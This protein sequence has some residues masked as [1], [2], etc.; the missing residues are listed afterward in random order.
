MENKFI[1]VNEKF[2]G[3]VAEIVIGPAPSNIVSEAVMA[4]VTAQLDKTAK[5]A[6]KKLIIL[7]G[8]GDNFSYGASV[9]EHAPD[10]VGS[11]LPK[12]HTFIE[13]ILCCPIPVMAKVKGKCL[14]GGYETV[15]ACHYIFADKTASFAVPEITLGVF[16]PPASILLPLIIGDKLACQMVLT[17]AAKSAD[18][19]KAANL[20]NEVSEN[21]EALEKT[22]ET[23]I[24]KR[25][26]PMSA[27]S[28][29]IAC[30]SVRKEI[31]EK[32]KANIKEIEKLYLKNLMSSHD[33]VEGI[34]AFMEKRQA[35]WKNN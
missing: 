24:T 22:I 5:D 15:I 29:R 32:Y 3:S 16:P 25:V 13:K 34:T 2:N 4:E 12:F 19:L 23:F 20:I 10:K 21:A 17:G 26:L 1:T 18:D 28:I 31:I 30:Q 11:M 14:G 9:P 8:A 7:T 27:S 33:A 6:N 35:V